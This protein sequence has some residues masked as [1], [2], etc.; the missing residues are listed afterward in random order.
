[1]DGPLVLE[2]HQASLIFKAECFGCHATA[3]SL[4]TDGKLEDEPYLWE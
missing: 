2:D 3:L 4:G 1:M